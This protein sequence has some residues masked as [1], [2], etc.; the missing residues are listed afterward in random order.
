MTSPSCTRF[1]LWHVPTPPIRSSSKGASSHGIR[2]DGHSTSS[3]A[4]TVTAVLT[5][6]SSSALQTCSRL[7]A[8]ST[9]S[10]S[11][12]TGAARSGI[13]RVAATRLR[14]SCLFHVV[15]STSFAGR[16]AR[17]LS[18]EGRSSSGRLWMVGMTTVTSSGLYLGFSQLGTL[19]L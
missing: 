11:I 9:W 18:S 7:F 17:M 19:D 12:S 2:V 3:S 10:T 15:T 16:Q 6:S 1:T 8:L 4:M 14:A 13:R 5:W